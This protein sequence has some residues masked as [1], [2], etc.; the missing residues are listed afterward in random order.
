[1]VP[2]AKKKPLWEKVL[3]VADMVCLIACIIL[4]LA[5]ICM[6]YP[7]HTFAITPRFGYQAL[8]VLHFLIH[9][10]LNWKDHRWF[11][12]FEL[13]IC[14]FGLVMLVLALLR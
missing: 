11:A 14:A 12:I 9:G 7:D 2:D 3:I 6:E 10:I 5:A 4:L 13:G 1:M 8:M